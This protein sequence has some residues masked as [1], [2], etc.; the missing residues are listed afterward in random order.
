MLS[1]LTTEI[2]MHPQKEFH[3][4]RQKFL[5]VYK[6]RRDNALLSHL[7]QIEYYLFC[8]NGSP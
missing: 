6:K 3:I 8:V 4:I 5:T 7:Y 1:T 2:M